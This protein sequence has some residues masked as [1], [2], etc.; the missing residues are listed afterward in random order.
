MISSLTLSVL[1][2]AINQALALDPGSQQA[3]LG[4]QD[5]IIKL[6]CF[7]PEIAFTAQIVSQ[8]HISL[9]LLSAEEQSSSEG[10]HLILSGTG[11][12]FVELLQHI[13]H[14]DP[15]SQ[16]D[17]K[18]EGDRELFYQLLQIF[19]QMDIDWEEGLSR[20][21]GDLASHPLA[22]SIRQVFQWQLKQVDSLSHVAAEYLQHEL[23]VFPSQR[24]FAAFKQ[25]VTEFSSSVQTLEQKVKQLAGMV[26]APIDQCDETAK[27]TPQAKD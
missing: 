14:A 27:P 4:A 22:N 8:D 7:S 17:L 15:L 21:I 24:E 1:Q 11:S 13:K 25:G 10:I 6:N 18:L 20:L 23:A 12:Q 16:V 5:K 26:D 2:S 3:L 19:Q 9:H